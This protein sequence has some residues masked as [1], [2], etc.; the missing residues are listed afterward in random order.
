MSEIGNDR[1]QF[2]TILILIT[3][4]LT[5][6]A[7]GEAIVKSIYFKCCQTGVCIKL[8]VACTHI[9]S[10]YRTSQQRRT[11]RPVICLRII[12]QYIRGKLRP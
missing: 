3:E 2:Y 1:R 6:L 9:G 10:T 11:E 7:A 5:I 12:D 4:N 8:I